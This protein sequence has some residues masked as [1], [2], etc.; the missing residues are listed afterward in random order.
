M[1]TQLKSD[2]SGVRLDS[3]IAQKTDL[4]RS[5]V[6]K[7]IDDGNVTVNGKTQKSS[8]I[9]KEN[10]VVDV[11]L[12]DPKP[13]DVH[14]VNIPIDI[15]YQDDDLAVINKPQGLTVH[16]GSGTDD[17]TLVNALLY[18]LDKLSGI[19]GVLRPGIVHR[20]DKDT[21]GLLVVAKNDKAHISLSAQ[22]AEKTCKRQYLALLHGAVKD[23]QG[24]IDTFLDRSKK[25]RTAY[26]VTA[27]QG[28][29][30][31]TFYRVI[32]RFPA[33]TLCEFTLMTGRTHQIRV[34]SKYIGHPVVGDKTYGPKK[35]PFDLNGQL[36]HAYKLT[37]TH[38]SSGEVMTFSCPL[39]DYFE[40]VLEKLRKKTK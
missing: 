14:P 18:S 8:Y 39:P 2:L 5:H 33:Y 3:F 28:R 17:N 37:F 27:S 9:V 21:S 30:A 11:I 25:D 38:P 13:L 10:D 26:T 40:N 4:S 36:L 32:E 20:I 6:K 24:K 35:C 1:V 23:D 7:A 19:N 16:A 29:R 15:I 34:H 22:I 12:S 31:L